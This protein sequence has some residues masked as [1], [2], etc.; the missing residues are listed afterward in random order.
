MHACARAR[1]CIRL[2]CS[3]SFAADPFSFLYLNSNL[4]EP[5]CPPELRRRAILR[6]ACDR[7]SA[8]IFPLLLSSPYPMIYFPLPFLLFAP[9]HVPSSRPRRY[10]GIAFSSTSVS[11][12]KDNINIF[13]DINLLNVISSSYPLSLS[14][15]D[16][17][18]SA[19]EAKMEVIADESS[20]SSG[21]MRK[22]QRTSHISIP[23]SSPS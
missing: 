19:S 2:Y 23:N 22:P 12:V 15:G 4:L 3:P 8:A 21:I 10:S 5:L 7:H 13:P 1:V 9:F 6:T 16:E 11:Q 20:F 17:N 14:L 18:L